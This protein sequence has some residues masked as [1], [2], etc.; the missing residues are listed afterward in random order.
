[1]ERICMHFQPTDSLSLIEAGSEYLDFPSRGW[2]VKARLDLVLHSFRKTVKA[3][4]TSG[5]DH[6]VQ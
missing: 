3:A 6:A 2:H 5:E 1:M 4:T